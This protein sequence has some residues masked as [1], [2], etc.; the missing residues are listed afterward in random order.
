MD[1]HTADLCDQF[2]EQ[3]QVLTPSL[4][5]YGGQARFFG[6]IET[7]KLFEDNSLL[8]EAL[9]QN[10]SGKVLVVDGGGS[11]RCALLGDQLGVL[12]VANGWAGLV[13]NGCVRDS[14]AL[15]KLALGV[16][17]LGVHPRKSVKRGEGQRNLSVEFGQVRFS[18]GHWL[19][20]DEDGVVVAPGA[21]HPAP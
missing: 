7:L 18:P 16:R 4:Q 17:A 15:N 19:Y 2:D 6:R 8:R 12:A 20:A 1:F 21:L 14:A 13:I 11:L 10:G 9:S 3:L 5:R